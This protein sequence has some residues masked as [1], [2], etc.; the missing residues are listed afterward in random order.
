MKCIYAA[1]A[2]MIYAGCGTHLAVAAPVFDG[3]YPVLCH[4]VPVQVDRYGVP[5]M[6]D[7][8]GDGRKDLIMGQFTDGM[9]RCYPN[10]GTDSNPVF[11][12]FFFVQAS[13]S[14]IKLPYG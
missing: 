6:G 1:I 14:V 9:I 5:A 2:L 12:T 7:L 8:T 4:G 3:P 13:G 11:D 10:I